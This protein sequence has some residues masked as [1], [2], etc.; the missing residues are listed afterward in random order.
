MLALITLAAAVIRFKCSG[1]PSPGGTADGVVA[2][3]KAQLRWMQ[4]EIVR[5]S[6]QPLPVRVSITRSCHVSL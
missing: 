4:D 5:P 1:A 6:C 3:T 2:P